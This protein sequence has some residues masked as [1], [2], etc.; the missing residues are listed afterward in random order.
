MWESRPLTR[1][2]SKS[3]ADGDSPTLLGPAAV[4]CMVR[5]A[6]AFTRAEAVARC[7]GEPLT[8]ARM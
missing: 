4:P 6:S 8:M 7:A 5:A 3:E 2:C 1:R